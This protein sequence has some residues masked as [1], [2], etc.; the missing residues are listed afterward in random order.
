MWIATWTPGRLRD[1]QAGV[2]RGRRRAPVLVQLEPAGARPQLLPQP[3]GADIVLP[4]PSSTMLTGH[5][6]SARSIASSQNAPGVTVV[7]LVPSAGPVPPPISVVMPAAMATG[8]CCG[9]IRCTW[10]SMPPAVRISPLPAMISVDGP[11]TSDRRYPVHRVGVAGLAQRDDPA[12]PDADVGLDH[13]PVVEHDRA[14]DHQ[15]GRALGAGGRRP[16]PSTRGSP[17]RRRTRPRRRPAAP[18]RR[19]GPRSPR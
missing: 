9:A 2:D 14:G 7:A 13:A 6:V 17:C 15:V 8:I 12:V 11:M 1:G 10:L 18:A 19:T 4:L 16:G 5:A 3:L